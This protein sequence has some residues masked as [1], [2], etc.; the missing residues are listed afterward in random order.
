MRCAALRRHAIR[1]ELQLDSADKLSALTF[2]KEQILRGFD[3]TI[4][5]QDGFFKP[6]FFASA[7]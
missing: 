7:M 2:R 6:D 4:E 5:S 1:Q 3:Q